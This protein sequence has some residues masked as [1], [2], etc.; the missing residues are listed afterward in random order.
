MSVD[1]G[2]TV[3]PEGPIKRLHVDQHRIRKGEPAMTV[4]TSRGPM[5]G[6]Q[7]YVAGSSTLVQ[8]E[9]PLSCGARV[10]IET[11]GE[12]VILDADRELYPETGGEMSLVTAAG[13]P[14]IDYPEDVK[15]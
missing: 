7:V 3:V 9:K 6:S 13:C 11:H 10:W 8:G 2:Y 14:F 15:S 1:R 4:Q 12:V 5:K